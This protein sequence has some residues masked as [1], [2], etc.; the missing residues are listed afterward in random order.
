ME[1]TEDKNVKSN[2]K[3]VILLVVGVLVLCAVSIL[4]I[5]IVGYIY[6]TKNKELVIVKE[7]E[8]LLDNSE[9]YSATIENDNPTCNLPK[10]EYEESA[11][12]IGVPNGWMYEVNNGT[13]SIMEDESNTTATFF[14]TAKLKKELTTDELINAFGEI[15]EQTI[16]S[17]G[18]TFQISNIVAGE[19]NA[20]ADII[21]RIGEDSM[22]G[23]MSLSKE[24]DF[25]V[26]KSY[27]API[28]SYEEKKPLL[29]EVC[30]CFA[31]T[32]LLT[33]ELLNAVKSRGDESNNIPNG[34][35]AYVGKYFKL[36]KPA[37]F[38]VTGETDS[39]IDLTRDDDN[40]GFSYAYAT[41][42]TGNYTVKSWAQRALTEFALIQNVSMTDG[43][44][45][46]S[47][48]SGH[49]IQE[50]GFTG[51]LWNVPVKGKITVGIYEAPYYGVGTRYSSAFWAIQIAESSNWEG[52]SSTLQLIQ[53]SFQIIDIGATRKNT[54][55]PSN[56]PME[57]SGS[58]ITSK[59]SSYSSALDDE[60]SENWAE[61]MRGY[62]TVSSPSTGQ[63]YDVPL[64]SWSSY[65]PE[66][67][68]Y[69]RQLPDN[70]VEKLN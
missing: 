41:G 14:Y 34:L 22:R 48:I 64:N 30:G 2:R 51:N 19:D 40:A 56:R 58:S 15:F 23:Q 66:G 25:V 4:G 31:R 39:G 45:L 50:F 53:D 67:P 12:S 8:G 29:E 57:S 13:V 20:S 28:V 17:V 37:N 18:G 59:S 16:A 44:S 65:G 9:F 27:W 54:L 1:N 43:N 52:A 68:G 32:K 11:F 21:A 7:E 26:F 5:A 10:I 62:E 33:P 69:Y 46:P 6:Y 49:T 36:N 55:L 35:T 47:E 61:G 3:K 24:G 60:S 70:S 38:T 42:F 63:S